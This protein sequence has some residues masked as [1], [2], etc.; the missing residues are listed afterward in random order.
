MW[1]KVRRNTD[2]RRIH[3]TEHHS[4]SGQVGQQACGGLISKPNSQ[5]N[6]LQ[7]ETANSKLIVIAGGESSFRNEFLSSYPGCPGAGP[8]E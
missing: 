4:P 8:G 3:S 6:R 7:L 2:Y 5:C 1:G